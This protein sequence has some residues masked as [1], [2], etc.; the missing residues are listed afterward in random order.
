MQSC[1]RSAARARGRRD[2][3]AR[4]RDA[5]PRGVADRA[6]APSHWLGVLVATAIVGRWAAMFLQALGDPILDDDS[7]RSL[8]ATPAP[9][10][11]TVA[12][13]LGVAAVAVLALG[14]AGIVALALTAA[15]RSCSASTRSA[16]ITA[17]PRRSSRPRRRSAS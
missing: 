10:W 17:C 2:D 9:A 6:A 11:L 14:K 1:T 7:P 16:A 15:L 3:A 13:S 8:V 5:G 12:L 4:V